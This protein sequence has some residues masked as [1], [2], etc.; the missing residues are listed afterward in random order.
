MKNLPSHVAII[1]DGNGRWAN[2]QNKDRLFGHKQGAK[3]VREITEYAREIGIK[4][5]TLYAFSEQNWNRPQMEVKGL[6]NLLKE[7]LT[8]EKNTILN[9]NIRFSCIGNLGKLPKI[10]QES[11]VFLTNLSKNNDGMDL[12]LALSYGGKEEIIDAVKKISE[13]CMSG[14]IRPEKIN[15]ELFDSYLYTKNLPPPDLLIRTS[16][17]RRISN[18]LLWQL[19]YTEF[20]F[21]DVPWPQF[22]K[23][24]FLMAIESFEK[25]E[26]RFGL[27][28]TQL[29]EI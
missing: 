21:I 10:I 4:A 5:L 28:S 15:N 12:C 19:A 20:Y 23:E 29:K 16:G 11:I 27:I 6:M 1:M 17:E 7:Y 25:R 3:V 14:K 18:F 13:D 24:H 9:N 2:Q 26:R 22:S 8:S